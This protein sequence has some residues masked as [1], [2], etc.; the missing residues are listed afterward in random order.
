MLVNVISNRFMK[1]ENK[2][3]SLYSFYINIKAIYYEFFYGMY[4]YMTTKIPDSL[5]KLYGYFF[6]LD[7]SRIFR[8][9]Q[10][11]LL[12]SGKQR[13]YSRGVEI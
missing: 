10:K 12:F 5:G 9:L 4:F 11:I 1:S 7:G 6:I 3:E 13:V 2:T 8:F